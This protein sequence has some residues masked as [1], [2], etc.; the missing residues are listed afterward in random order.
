[1]GVDVGIAV[2]VRVAVPVSGAVADAVASA[3]RV[4]LALGVALRL[5][6]ALAVAV[7]LAAG[8]PV[9]VAV[10]PGS[11][12]VEIVALDVAAVEPVGVAVD[13]AAWVG[14]AVGVDEQ[15]SSAEET[16]AMS[17]S[18]VIRPSP[19]PSP[20]GQASGKRPL[21]PLST[22]VISSLT[23]TAPL[24]S[25]SPGQAA[26]A[27]TGVTARSVAASAQRADEHRMPCP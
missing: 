4:G 7:G 22:R 17:S 13:P 1:V 18:M 14:L 10:S 24:P 11:G 20:A 27:G 6:S 15:P 5:G 21:R 23:V 2:R 3:L 19:F 16:A 26:R 12:V 9:R 8:V 25:Q